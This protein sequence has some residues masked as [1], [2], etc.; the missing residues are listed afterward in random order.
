MITSHLMCANFFMVNLT[1]TIT[2]ML[3]LFNKNR[4]TLAK[5][6]TCRSSR[7]E[8]FCKKVVL[9]N[10]TKFTGKYMCQ[11]LFFNKVAVVY[12][13]AQVFSYE[14]CEIS[15]NTFFHGTPLVAATVHHKTIP[16]L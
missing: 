8:V 9:R 4:E 13:M 16:P 7:P 15:E 2:F 1:V 10:F 11:S 3:Q 14:F 12:N 6:A 5:H